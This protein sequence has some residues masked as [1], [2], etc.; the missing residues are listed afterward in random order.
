[1]LEQVF[2]ACDIGNPCLEYNQYIS[3]ASLLSYEFN[4]Q[5]KLEKEKGLEVTEMF[6]YKGKKAFLDGQLSF[7]SN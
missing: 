3:W 1:M 6:R 2:H 7:I 5:F 4:E